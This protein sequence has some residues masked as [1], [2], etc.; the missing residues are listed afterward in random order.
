MRQGQEAESRREPGLDPLSELRKAYKGA[1]LIGGAVIAS[2]F[3]YGVCVEVIRALFKPFVGFGRV[4][5]PLGLR[6]TF[7]AAAIVLVIV[8]RVLNSIILRNPGRD[9]LRTTVRK[10]TRAALVSMVLAESPA[11]LGFVLFLVG[12]FSR[13][14]YMLLMVSLFLEFMYF[15]RLRNWK[16]YVKDKPF[17]CP[18]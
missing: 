5:N 11:I 2:L 15:P 1:S 4:G 12:G 6:Y 8:N 9:N 17:R 10:L 14:F 18:M 7:Y 16:N 3:V 13:D